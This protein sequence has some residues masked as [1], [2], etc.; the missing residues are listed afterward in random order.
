MR[1]STAL[2][3]LVACILGVT[4]ASNVSCCPNDTGNPVA[5]CLSTLARPYYLDLFSKDKYDGDDDIVTL[6][7]GRNGGTAGVQ[8]TPRQVLDVKNL[9][10]RVMFSATYT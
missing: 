1:A 3:V 10:T 8:G 9:L 7:V 5:V 2:V 6:D 4:I